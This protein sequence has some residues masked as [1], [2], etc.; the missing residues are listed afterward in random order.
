M[1]TQKTFCYI[2]FILNYSKLSLKTAF[3]SSFIK[4]QN[5]KTF[6]LHKISNIFLYFTFEIY[7][8]KKSKRNVIHRILF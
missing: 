1:F 3:N 6:Y 4:L 8:L 5:F 7:I 2:I